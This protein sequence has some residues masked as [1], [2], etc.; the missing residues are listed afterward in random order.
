MNK[1]KLL[2]LSTF[3]ISII[4]SACNKSPVYYKKVKISD[5]TPKKRIVKS[6]TTK[7]YFVAEFS[8]EQSFKIG[9]CEIPLPT[10]VCYV[11]ENENPNYDLLNS[12][13]KYDKYLTSYEQ[14]INIGIYSTDLAFCLLNRNSQKF[15]EYFE[16]INK[17]NF[18]VGIDMGY[19]KKF[20]TKISDN[21]DNFDSLNVYSNR[22]LK[23]TKIFFEN[24]KDNDIVPFI[25]I[26]AWVENM[27][28]LTNNANSDTENSEIL[29]HISEQKLIIEEFINYFNDL[30][31]NVKSF[32][33]NVKIQEVISELEELI[34]LYNKF[35]NEEGSLISRENLELLNEKIT[36]IRTKFV[37]Y[38][39]ED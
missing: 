34:T 30:M 25:I 14:A 35:S 16:V 27:Y 24:N 2:L 18:Q 39:K 23:H 8:K 1:I 13:A 11:L 19:K 6:N 31:I 22:V 20:L 38:E 33:A 32:S 5:L 37:M 21:I 36:S 7:D 4:F 12:P 10:S 3:L 29:E 26:G 9:K 15:N 17:L 28:L